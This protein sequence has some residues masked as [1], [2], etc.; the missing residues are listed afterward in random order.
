MLTN[1]LALAVLIGG[2]TVGGTAI[3]TDKSDADA[4]IA[5]AKAAQQAA[6]SVGGEWR[7]TGKLIEA[8]E[9]AVAEGNFGTA[10]DL[11][12]Q[13]EGQGMLGKDQALGQRGVGNPKYLYN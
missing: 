4:A 3:A 6:S 13:A 7:D 5:A 12:K 8:A 1:K 2:L 10:V 11:A 9:K